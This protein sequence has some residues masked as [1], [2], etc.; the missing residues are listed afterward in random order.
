MERGD[1]LAVVVAVGDEG[2]EAEVLGESGGAWGDSS[3]KEAG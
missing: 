3:T 1:L 2:E